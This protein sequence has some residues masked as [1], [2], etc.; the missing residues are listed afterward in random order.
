MKQRLIYLF[1]ALLLLATG[2][3]AQV[4]VKASTDRN[5]ILIGEPISLT[6]QAYM[7]L[8]EKVEGFA[9][10]SMEH[11]NVLAASKIDTARS[12]DLVTFTQTL[13]ITSFD[14]GRWQIPP[15]QFR[16]SAAVYQTDSISIDVSY[17]EFDPK[18]DYREI[19][20]IE[21]VE[22][23]GDNKLPWIIGITT[24]L[25]AIGFWYFFRKK[26]PVA[27][28][29]VQK[30]F[31]S[32]YMEAMQSLD[33]LAKRADVANGTLKQYYSDL[34]D[35]LRV[36]LDREL[37]SATMY[38]TNDELLVGL[39]KTKLDVEVRG[40]LEQALRV[41]DF[42]KFAK[43]EPTGEDNRT[44]LTIVR[45]AIESLHKQQARAIPVATGN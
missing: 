24:L 45:N 18:E 20:S 21:T 39:R 41:A 2:A 23:T 42:V 11:F 33:A 8:G 26:K 29:Q 32:P 6:L 10:D 5:Q 12:A 43:Y 14:S 30:P 13:K 36:Y 25:A 27:A 34:N 22:V 35:I 15:I 37:F 28:K 31:L 3:S 17:S 40:K 9:L 38:Q 1:T 44:N 4:S 16:T 7:P 19:K